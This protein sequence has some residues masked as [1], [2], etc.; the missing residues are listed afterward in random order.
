MSKVLEANNLV[1]TNQRT[2]YHTC[3]II[4]SLKVCLSNS[5]RKIQTL[6]DSKQVQPTGTIIN[7][8]TMNGQPLVPSGIIRSSESNEAKQI[9]SVQNAQVQNRLLFSPFPKV[10]HR[11]KIISVLGQGTFSK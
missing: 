7:S 10:H 6:M 5:S 1:F 2:R 3:V 4:S 9:E 8:Y 11:Y